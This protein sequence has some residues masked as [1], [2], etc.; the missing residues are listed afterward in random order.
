MKDSPFLSEIFISTW[1]K[2]FNG[3]NKTYSFN[4]LNGVSFVRH[5]W[6]PFYSNVG[7][8]IT[9]GMSYTL[10]NLKIN[11]DFKNKVFLVYDVPTYFNLKTDTKNSSLKI[12]KIRQYKGFLS[13]LSEHNDFDTFFTKQFKSSSRYKF[14]QKQK[15]L[16]TCFNIEYP[17]YYGDITKEDYNRVIAEFKGLITKRFN[18]IGKDNDV[19][20]TWNYY[21]DLIYPMLKNKQ[22]VLI[23]IVKDRETIGGAICFLSNHT[24]FYAITTFDSDYYK[25][26]L[27]HTIINK[28]MNWCYEND[29]ESFDFSKGEYEY[30]SRWTNTEY[31]YECHVLYDSK[32]IIASTIALIVPNYFTLKQYLRDKNINLLLTKIKFLF[33]NFNT[34]KPKKQSYKI[35]NLESEMDFNKT[36]RIDINNSD[37]GF[38]RPIIYDNLYKNSEPI[39][40]IQVYKDNSSYAVIGLK[41]SY[42]II[43]H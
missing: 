17:V 16:D 22:A 2:H 13:F 38:L 1:L 35:E 15:R 11:T 6:L 25:F 32:S 3:A 42:K 27:G 43:F 5:K 28:L 4:F 14:R 24:L 19:L 12:K 26:N 39:A 8:N 41:N 21:E 33:K 20:S 9:N 18:E 30:K 34:V 7:R 36:E 37:N 40:N 23:A 10:I 31:S 29:I